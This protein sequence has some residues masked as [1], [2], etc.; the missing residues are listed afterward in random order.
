[1]VDGGGEGGEGGVVT[2]LQGRKSKRKNALRVE[3]Y[4]GRSEES[5]RVK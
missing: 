1:M 3:E 2:C 4:V 5:G